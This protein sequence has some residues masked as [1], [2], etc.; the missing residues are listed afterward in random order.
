MSLYKKIA[1]IH[2]RKEAGGVVAY[3]PGMTIDATEAELKKHDP[4]LATW[5]LV[6]E[7][8]E[9]V[10]ETPVLPEFQIEK[11]GEKQYNV[12]NTATGEKLNDVPLTRKEA[13]SLIKTTTSEE[14]GTSK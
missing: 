12:I 7:V 13:Y 2:Y 6:E 11:I 8:V 3:K 9:K 14:D 5:K 10:E 4:E 1:G